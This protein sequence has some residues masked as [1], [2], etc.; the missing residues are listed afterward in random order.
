M[1]PVQTVEDGSTDLVS[2]ASL[3]PHSLPPDSFVYEFTSIMN[4]TL[5][6]TRFPLQSGLFEPNCQ[7]VGKAVPK[8]K[9]VLSRCGEIL[10]A[11]LFAAFGSASL[12]NSIRTSPLILTLPWALF[13]TKPWLLLVLRLLPVWQR[14]DHHS[15]LIVVH[16]H[17]HWSHFPLYFR[18][19]PPSS[20]F[21]GLRSWVCRCTPSAFPLPHTVFV[22]DRNVITLNSYMVT[23]NTHRF[24][25]HH[26]QTHF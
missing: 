25:R 2:M 11:S 23:S 7:E 8:R 18:F 17:R 6:S 21:C 20:S 9:S 14:Y 4:V 5:V 12:S 16:I 26:T 15:P 22:M 13:S 19:S 24:I 1:A 10:A 3:Q